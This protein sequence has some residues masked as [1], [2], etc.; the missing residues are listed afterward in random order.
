LK[1]TNLQQDLYLVLKYLYENSQK[2]EEFLK[3]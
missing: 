1:E 3:E 2:D